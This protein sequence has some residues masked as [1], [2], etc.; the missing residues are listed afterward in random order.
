MK[1]AMARMIKMANELLESA[2]AQEG[3][4]ITPAP[5]VDVMGSPGAPDAHIDQFLSQEQM[6]QQAQDTNEA[7]F[8][9]QKFQ[10]AQQQLQQSMQAA[11][12]QQQQMDQMSQQLQGMQGQID[13]AL[14][15][16]Q[17]IQQTAMTN[18]QS[19][20]AAATQAMQQT[21]A[22]NS[23]LINQQQL[24]SNMRNAY[25]QLQQQ[26]QQV[27][28]TAP[29]PATTMEAGAVQTPPAMAGGAPGG[30]PG[31]P[32]Q[33]GQEPGPGPEATGAGQPGGE[34]TPTA[35]PAGGPTPGGQ[36]AESGA[37]GS[38]A[39]QP[40]AD[41]MGPQ[42]DQTPP[43]PEAA[44]VS[45]QA[46]DL[47]KYLMVDGEKYASFLADAQFGARGIM[48]E[49]A[50]ELIGA[51]VGA[52]GVGLLPFGLKGGEEQLAALRQH[53]AD[54]EA[55]KDELGWRDEL[56]HITDKTQLGMGEFVQKHPIASHAVGALTGASVGA[57]VGT[58]I[59]SEIAKRQLALGGY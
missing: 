36:G 30:P 32:E 7:N 31:A 26:I 57:G 24:S 37:Q 6:M 27:A 42:S 25:Q 53:V 43:Q 49:H 40:T 23:E 15:Q 1:A 4:P 59:N 38:A 50:P 35:G 46:S 8:Y 54:N 58:A 56:K 21:L 16:G 52:V 2:G 33:A 51:G 19:A 3:S 9:R 34:A 10:E 47:E 17:Q 29:P 44:Q 48:K 22:A 12:S 39:P 18:A 45:K 41:R 28:Q 13:G 5:P 55:R 20:Q 11:Q 14:Q